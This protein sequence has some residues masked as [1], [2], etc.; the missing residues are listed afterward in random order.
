MRDFAVV[1][2]RTYEETLD[3]PELNGKRTAD[4]ILAGHRGQGTFHPDFWWLAFDGSTPVGLLLLMEMS[5]AVTWELAYLGIVP[6]YRRL[7]LGRE[8]TVHALY[9]LR[10]QPATRMH[11]CVD[12]RNTPA[13]RLYQSL[14]FT[15]SEWSDVLLYFL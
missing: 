10:S 11:L 8:M 4:E 9:A 5:D 1:L 14:G 15:E 2:D 13:R 12:E 6:E 3:C 7:G